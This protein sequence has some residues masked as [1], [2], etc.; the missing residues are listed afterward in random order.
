MKSLI[1]K[2]LFVFFV[3]L[4]SSALSQS[5]NM[6][7]SYDETFALSKDMEVS[8]FNKYGDIQ[9]INWDKDSV[10]IQAKVE[11]SSHKEHKAEKLYDAIN[12]DFRHNFFYVIAETEMLGKNSV[13]NDLSDVTKQLFNSKTTSKIDYIVHIPNNAHLILKNKY[14][15]IYLGDYEGELDIELS[16]GDLKGHDLNGKTKLNL[17]FGDIYLNKLTHAILQTTS[18]EAEIE[19]VVFLETHTRSSKLFLENVKELNLDSSHDKYHIG[20]LKSISGKGNFTFIKIKEVIQIVDINQKY[21]SL[22]FKN[23]NNGLEKFSLNTYKSD[24]HLNLN[25]KD[26]YLL[27]FTTKEPPQIQ[28][29]T[30]EYKKSEVVINEEDDTKNIQI[31]WGDENNKDILP[32]H[33]QAEEGNVF[34]N[35]K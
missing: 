19:E 12:I 18:S 9:V 32:I 29:P 4:A 22:H 7:K 21:G 25:Y 8:I 33:I 10:R 1:Y 30:G 26:S 24:I 15:N 13:W 31:I 6:S 11:V 27:D 35:V 14:G 16:N 23:I 5:Y 28:Y 3:L 20:E 17:S 2:Y 34:I